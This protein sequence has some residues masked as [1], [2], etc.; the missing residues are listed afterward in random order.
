MELLKQ[1]ANQKSKEEDSKQEEEKKEPPKPK[2][3]WRAPQS[4]AFS[5]LMKEEMSGNQ[6]QGPKKLDK[7]AYAEMKASNETKK[8]FKQQEEEPTVFGAPVG[9]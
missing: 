7:G 4:T 2:K 6:D 1:E 3:L 9:G 8:A 5:Q